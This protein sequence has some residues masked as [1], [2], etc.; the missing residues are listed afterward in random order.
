MW[1][2]LINMRNF[3]DPQYKQWRKQVYQRDNF[4]C[5]WPYCNTKNK[6]NAHPGLRF[7]LNNGITLCKYHHDLI[8]NNEDGYSE[9]FS[10]I[11]LNKRKL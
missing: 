5:Q 8:K 4:V 3:K 11:I 7:S 1:Q 9:F 2:R 10:K 6:L